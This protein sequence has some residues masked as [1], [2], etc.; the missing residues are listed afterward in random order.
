[1][2]VVMAVIVGC[3]V[4]AVIQPIYLS[5]GSIAGSTSTF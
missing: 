2:I 3:I 4:V 5:Y 1:M